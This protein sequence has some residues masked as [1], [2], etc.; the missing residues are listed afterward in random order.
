MYSAR[1]FINNNFDLSLIPTEGVIKEDA[2]SN[3]ALVKYWGKFSE[4]IPMNPSVSFT[5][6][7]SKTETLAKYKKTSMPQKK[8]LFK[9]YFEG[10]HKPDFEPK[11]ETFFNRIDK[12]VPFLKYFEFEFDSQNSFPHSSG[13]ASSASG[14]AALAKIIISMEKQLSPD[15]GEDYLLKKASFLA[16]LGSGSAARSIESPVTI[17]GTHPKI[18][19]SSNL[20]A[21][22]PDFKIHSNFE[23]YQD[24][25]ILIE[26]GQKQV[27]SSLGHDLMNRHIFKDIRRKQAFEHALKMTEILQSGD[28]DD[29]V[30]LVE[31]EALTLHALMMTSVPN[32]ILM[33]PQTL[34]MMQQIRV[35]RQQTGVKICFTLDAGA[36]IHILYPEKEKREV[37]DFIRSVNKQDFILDSI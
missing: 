12:Y 9:F 23:N 4:Q 2:P 7:K 18:E 6:S 30:C 24:S 34:E 33:L 20:Y 37:L 26:K 22:Q 19:N 35:Y 32:Y 28:L 17:W 29:F 31:T 5:L 14:F 1:N 21:I 16:R 25:I 3:I 27:S 13:I 10:V 15:L 36:N 11:I 8:T